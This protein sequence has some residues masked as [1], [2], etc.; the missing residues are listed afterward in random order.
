MA[1]APLAAASELT[2]RAPVPTWVAS[3]FPIIDSQPRL[4]S[5]VERAVG[6]HKQ[7][8]SWPD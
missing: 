3:L 8:C 7:R 4:R 1:A 2:R 6:T 5:L